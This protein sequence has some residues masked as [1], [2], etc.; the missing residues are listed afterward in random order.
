M[1]Q[2]SK[3]IGRLSLVVFLGSILI[4]TGLLQGCQSYTPQVIKFCGTYNL[5]TN[6]TELDTSYANKGGKK[7]N[8]E[9]FYITFNK[10]IHVMKWDFYSL[11]HE[12]YH[13]LAKNGLIIEDDF[14][15]FK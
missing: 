8:I 1:K 3:S 12:V 9:A 2:I 11:G 14:E 6:K 15:H 5:Y 7:D 10:S 4:F 13:G